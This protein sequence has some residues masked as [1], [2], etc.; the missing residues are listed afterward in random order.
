MKKRVRGAL[1]TIFID[2]IGLK[3]ISLIASITLF[4]VVHGAED[5]QK[6][7]YVD[8]IS[9]LPEAS[10]G[11][12]LVSDIPVRV[13]VTLAGSPAQLNAIRPDDVPPLE[14]DLRDTRRVTYEI[15][16]SDIDVPVGVTVQSVEPHTIALDWVERRERRVRVRPL[17]IGEP[18]RGFV[19][20]SP[21]RVDPEF[22]TL[23]GPKREIENL[24]YAET[25]EVDLAGLLEGRIE[26]RV[27]LVHLPEHVIVDGDSAVTL[28]IDVVPE[29][30]ERTIARVQVGA[31]G[32]SARS[33]RPGNVTISLF[34]PPDLVQGLDVDSVLP[35][36]DASSVRQSRVPQM[37]EVQVGGLPAGIEVRRISPPRVLV[38]PG[39]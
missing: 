30:A 11:R 6:S 27:R 35:F 25:T 1:R 28:A 24:E 36:V 15:D 2:D 16:S 32:A 38:T 5:A 10:S 3:L 7:I 31:V 22:V 39:G 18:R 33:I 23:I 37:L 8:V 14:L 26:R 34:G 20:A 12:M 9:T 13:R 21:P 17:L 29:R 4:S 19:L